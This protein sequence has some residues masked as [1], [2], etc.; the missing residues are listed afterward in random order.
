MLFP[1]WRWKRRARKAIAAGH[2]AKCAN[3]DDPIVPGDFV[4]RGLDGDQPVLVH[5]GFHYTLRER[6]AFCETGAVGTGFWTE[7]GF[8]GTGESLAAKALRTGETQAM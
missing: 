4:T 7:T 1:Y 6:D 2:V 3:C 5:A 8:M